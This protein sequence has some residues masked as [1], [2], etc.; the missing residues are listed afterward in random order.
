MTKSI[1][2]A[3][4]MFLALSLTPFYGQSQSSEEACS[5][6]C[7]SNVNTPIDPINIIS[8]STSN[9]CLRITAQYSGGCDQH[10]VCLAWNGAL[11]ESFP[12]Q[13]FLYLVHRDPGDPCDGI[14]T[15][16]LSYD[17]TALQDKSY[18]HIILRIRD[19]NQQITL[20]YYY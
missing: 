16:Y 14:V 2:L 15:R 9:N 13:A 4:G 18:N 12:P 17:L 7:I 1:F 3:F 11:A 6:L 20:P 19:G 8:A 10:K 5:N